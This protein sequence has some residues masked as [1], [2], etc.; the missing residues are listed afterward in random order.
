MLDLFAPIGKGQRALIVAPP[1]T[2]KT[3]LMKELAYGITKNHPEVE[4]IVLLVDERPEEVTDIKE[5][6]EGGIIPMKLVEDKCKKI[7]QYK[8]VAGSENRTYTEDIRFVFSNVF[9]KFP[10]NL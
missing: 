8:Y 10:K 3:E 2:G 6:I 7:L 9:Q 1:R 5:A 4:L